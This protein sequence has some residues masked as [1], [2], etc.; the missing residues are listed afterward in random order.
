MA[1]MRKPLRREIRWLRRA[2]RQSKS[3]E[4][5]NMTRSII[6]KLLGAIPPENT[7]GKASTIQMLKILLPTML[8]TRRSDSP[9]LAALMVVTSSGNEVPNATMVSE[10]IRSEMPAALAIREAELTTNWLP[11]TTPIKPRITRK[12]DLPS[13]YLGLLTLPASFLFLRARENR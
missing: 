8:P 2:S 4:N 13:L 10:M 6:S 7:T 9:F 1:S 11:T 3:E 12:N 5:I